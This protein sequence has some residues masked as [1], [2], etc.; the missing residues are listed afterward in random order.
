MDDTAEAAIVKKRRR[1]RVTRGLD[2]GE[3]AR[4]RGHVGRAGALALDEAVEHNGPLGRLLVGGRGRAVMRRG[5]LAG[6]RARGEGRV[7]R[8]RRFRQGG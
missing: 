7:R 8:S 2:G 3:H 1:E 4:E 6:G 5:G